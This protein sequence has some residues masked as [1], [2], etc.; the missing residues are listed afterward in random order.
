LAEETL[1]SYRLLSEAKKG[2]EHH[3]LDDPTVAPLAPVVGKITSAVL[4]ASQGTPLD[5]PNAG[6]YLKS[7]GLNL[8]EHSSGKHQ[9][10]LKITKRGSGI[11]RKY[12][13]LA[14]L[15]LIGHDPFAQ[16]WYQRKV[17]RDGG[18]KGKAI[19]AIMRKLTKS[20]WYVAQGQPF[21]TRRLFNTRLLNLSA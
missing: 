7:I 1:R 21:D 12:L 17:Q 18:R 6:S 14:A 10:Q 4:V 16:A 2:V 13:Y 19:V 11:A 9:G 5:Y 8:K 20:L 15:R 3:A